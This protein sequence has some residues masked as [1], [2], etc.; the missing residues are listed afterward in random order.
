MMQLSLLGTATYLHVLASLKYCNSYKESQRTT[1]HSCVALFQK[2]HQ[3]VQRNVLWI[4]WG[5]KGSNV[6]T[7]LSRESRRLQTQ[8]LH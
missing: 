6:N 8:F 2:H 3:N 1:S 5:R 7:E 4:H